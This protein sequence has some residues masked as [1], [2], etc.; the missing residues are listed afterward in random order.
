MSE[1]YADGGSRP[2]RSLKDRANEDIDEVNLPQPSARLSKVAE[3]P[4]H[5]LA[6]AAVERL[7]SRDEAFDFVE[8]GAQLL[9][10]FGGE[11]SRIFV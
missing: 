8:A 7:C 1:P 2:A 9:H 10:L 5:C 4:L 6:A 11:R 3:T